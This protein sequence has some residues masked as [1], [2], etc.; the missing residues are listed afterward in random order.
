MPYSARIH[1]SQER[2]DSI[3]AID[4]SGKRLKEIGSCF[5]V[6]ESAVSQASS[7]FERML[8]TNEIM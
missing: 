2:R 1:H 3:S 7:R 4:H 5:G 6:G 8:Q